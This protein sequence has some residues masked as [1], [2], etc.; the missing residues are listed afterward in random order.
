MEGVDTT[1]LQRTNQL[2]TGVGL[3]VLNQAG[4]NGII[5]D[6]SANKL[7]DAPYVDQAEAQIARSAIVMSVLEIPVPAAARAMELGRRHD[8]RTLLNPA[9]AA[10][11]DDATLRNCDIVTPNES[12]LRILM[13]LAPDDPCPTV[14]LAR[15]LQARG[16]QTVIVTMGEKG[17]LLM[18]PDRGEPLLVPG[19]AVDVVDTT[20]AGDAF[21]AGL[22]VALAEGQD[23]L[24]AI[25]FAN[26][27]GALACT[28]LG[29]IP[30]MAYRAD[31]ERLFTAHYR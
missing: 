16:A 5:L 6:M 28:K 23:M 15:Q 17:A 11:L 12:E 9:P 21:N 4:E 25:K 2:A 14:D 20:G 30:A 19:I 10:P 18:S 29:V 26:C 3:I 13:G 8:V 27:A 1:Y 7:M 24:T 31:V 22:A